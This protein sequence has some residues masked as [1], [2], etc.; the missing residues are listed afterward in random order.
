MDWT[1]PN[2][3]KLRKALLKIY[4]ERSIR[5]LQRFVRDNFT[6]SLSDIGGNSPADWAEELI[7]KS[8]AEGW[9]NELYQK[10]CYNHPGHS[11]IEELQGEPSLSAPLIGESLKVNA[12][13][14]FASFSG[15]DVAIFQKAFLRAFREVYGDSKEIPPDY[16]PLDELPR[17]QKLIESYEP[18]LAVRFSEYVIVEFKRDGQDL[19]A[20]MQWRDRTAQ[21][22]NIPLNPP[23]AAQ[24]QQQ[25]YLLV[26]LKESARKTGDT[27][28]VTVFAE[29]HVTGEKAPVEFGKTTVTCSL[30]EVAGHLSNLIHQAEIS[31][32]AYGSG[33]ITLELFLPWKH[34]DIDVAGWEF[35]LKRGQSRS[36]G[37]Q[38]DFVIRSL[39]RADDKATKEEVSHKWELLK[40][41]ERDNDACDRFHPQTTCPAVGDL[42][43]HLR[44]KPGLKL[45]ER[46]EDQGDYLE[47]LNDIIDSAV[48]IA[49]WFSAVEGIS[50]AEKLAEFDAL[51]QSSC[52]GDLTDFS[53]LANRWAIQRE[54]PS[55]AGRSHF[56]LLCDRPDRWPTLPSN[57]SDPL[58]AS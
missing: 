40:D 14:L 6:Y 33:R 25:G 8:V 38:R 22:Y 42:S 34:L 26:A 12:Q 17:I 48:P 20:V 32:S 4:G 36:L 37:T 50:V 55:F 7:E 58:I 54:N 45:L 29:L 41:C 21:Q 3:G 13:E 35:L 56:R 57:Q 23:P 9:I 43:L 47:I 18:E 10:V 28:F 51:L 1:G 27:A 24:V 5:P 16:L 49:L 30:D 31:L 46:P 11:A 15:Y 53:K 2:Q 52:S 39:D 44:D 19:T